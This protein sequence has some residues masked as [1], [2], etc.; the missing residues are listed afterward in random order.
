MSPVVLDQGRLNLQIPT[1][2]ADRAS[3]Q[4]ALVGILGVALAI[5]VLARPPG[6][7]G[8]ASPIAAATASPPAPSPGADAQIAS[9][10]PTGG[11]VE[12][13]VPAPTI[14]ALPTVTDQPSAT[15]PP[16]SPSNTPSPSATPSSSASV[17]PTLSG[18]TYVV[19]R[20]DNLYAIATRFGTTTQVLIK[21][22]AIAD[23][24]KLKVGQI[25]VLP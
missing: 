14:V 17:E 20:G 1:L 21:L 16:S 5:V 7:P 22:N 2:R 24:R 10:P 3:G 13:S 6:E 25:L 4:A 15:P 19:K 12:T 23:P 8:A 9:A 18:E 11:P